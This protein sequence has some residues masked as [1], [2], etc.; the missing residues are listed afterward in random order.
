VLRHT[1]GV[2]AVPLFMIVIGVA[3]SR[4]RRPRQ[5]RMTALAACFGAVYFVQGSMWMLQ[6]TPTAVLGATPGSRVVMQSQDFTCVPASCATALNHLGIRSTEAE[7]AAL[8]DARPGTGST[9]IRAMHGLRHR[10]AGTGISLD[11][12]QPDYDQLRS[13][14]PPLLTPLRLD[15]RQMHMVVI[16]SVHH[17]F[18]RIADPQEGVIYLTRQEFNEVYTGQVLCFHRP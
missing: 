2:G 17:D 6:S 4:A 10:L 12:V 3:W 15:P 8:T 11:L 7:M 5:R 1:E 14:H 18:V 13:L 9:M 16:L